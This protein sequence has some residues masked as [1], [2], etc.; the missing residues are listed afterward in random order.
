VSGEGKKRRYPASR[1]DIQGSLKQLV[2]VVHPLHQLERDADQKELS[3]LI[4]DVAACANS[5]R[6]VCEETTASDDDVENVPSVGTETSPAESVEAHKDVHH[7]YDGDK[8]EKIICT[9]SIRGKVT[10]RV[11]E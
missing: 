5:H 8:E 3:Q 7:V 1:R 10:Q 9:H 6:D 4:N 11:R 2:Q